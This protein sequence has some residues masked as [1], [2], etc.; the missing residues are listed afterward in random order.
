ME[1]PD[2][3]VADVDTLRHDYGRFFAEPLERG[4]GTTLGNALRRVLLASLPG[5]AVTAV[6]IEGVPHEYSTVDGVVEDVVQLVLNLKQIRFTSTAE[7]PHVCRIERS[8]VGEVTAADIQCPADIEVTNPDQHIANIDEGGSLALNLTV[9]TDHGFRVATFEKEDHRV[10]GAIPV[11]AIFSPVR[12]AN[13]S[14]EQTRVGQQTDF[15]RLVLDVWTDSTITPKEALTEAARILM[16]HLELFCDFDET[17]V[18]EI[19]EE[20]PEERQ[21]RALL[22]KPVAEL[23]LPVRAANCMET[24]GIRTVRDLVGKG[25]REMLALKNFGRKSL[26]E[27]KE[28][29]KGLDLDF[30][31]TFD[32]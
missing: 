29:L 5:T 10:I 14:V 18:E 9:E 8:G 27:V 21:L 32:N 17:Y 3:L 4:Y 24:A 25:E 15:D 7:R 20:S 11:D 28:I 16:K 6:E 13:F 30:G 12:R 26:N 31:T 19:E 2:R 22:D 23:E 1:M